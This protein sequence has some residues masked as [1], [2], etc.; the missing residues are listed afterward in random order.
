MPHL[1][2]GREKLH[3]ATSAVAA[4]RRRGNIA[5]LSTGPHISFLMLAEQC[6][7]AMMRCVFANMSKYTLMVAA[8]TPSSSARS[9]HR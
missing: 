2:E 5:I 8:L 1:H 4:A 3:L 6:L 9:A 7:R